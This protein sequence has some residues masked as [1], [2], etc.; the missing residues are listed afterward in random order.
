MKLPISWLNEFVNVSDISIETLKDKFVNIGFEVD[1][2]IHFGNNIENVVVGEI[3]SINKHTNSDKLFI[4]QV[5]VGQWEPLIIVTG[6]SNL[7]VGNK[8]PVALDGAILPDKKI[9]A[10]PLRGVMSYGMLCSGSELGLNDDIIEGAEVN[11]ILI[12][13]KDAPVGMDIKTFLDIDDYILDISITSNR[14]DCQSILGL[15][16][17]IA[18][19]LGRKIKLPDI[20]YE[21]DTFKKPSRKP[22]IFIDTP[23]CSRYT[24]R[25]I[26][27]VC[28]KKSPY[29]MRKRLLMCGIRPINNAVDITNY[30]LLEIGQPLHAFDFALVEGNIHVRN[31]ENGE[32]ITALNG[33]KYPLDNSVMVIADDKKAL[34]IA[35]VM[36]GEYSGI[37]E[38]TSEIY[39][40]S[41]RFNKQSIRNTSRKL[42]LSSESS[43]RYERGVDFDSIDLGR[44]RALNLFYNLKVGKILDYNKNVDKVKPEKKTITTSPSEISKLLG[45]KIER[46]DIVKILNLLNFTVKSEKGNLIIDVPGYREDIDNYTDIAEEVIRFYGYDK[47]SSTLLAASHISEGK[48]SKESTVTYDIKERLCALGCFEI[49]NFSFISDK[50]CDMLN[51]PKDSELR[52]VVKI[53]NPLSEEQSVMRTQLVSSMLNTIALNQ[54]RK[55]NS[56]RLFE[57]SKTFFD[58]G[59]D[60]PEERE[61]LCIGLYGP[62]EDFFTAKGIVESVMSSLELSFGLVRSN[63]SYLHPGLSADIVC[64]EKTIGRLGK[65]HPKVAKNFKLKNNVFVIE[66][67]LTDLELNSLTPV[68]YKELPKYHSV[69]RDLAFIVSDDITVGEMLEAIKD[70]CGTLTSEVS[71][72]DI[73]RGEG[74]PTGKYS[75][76]FSIKLQP[77]DKTLTDE[78][79]TKITDNIIKTISEKFNAILRE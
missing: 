31:A 78:E 50:T 59:N 8:V 48:R 6:A 58:I 60:L 71:L 76:A 72:F 4:C 36:G 53:R 65:I 2:V 69:D 37:N 73:Y 11:G 7:S 30:V 19:A 46:K 41:A 79:I 29:W 67:N 10:C 1:E 44:D 16:R 43:L 77:Y 40:E 35:G 57:Q 63:I 45:I 17:E 24:G 9:T 12:L 34:A 28:L 23:D 66:I 20:L 26:S 52:N 22:E 56:A 33:E 61:E 15:S 14:P 70:C 3:L 21:V 55:N 49:L 42:G 25:I 74:I 39:L 62:E 38:N 54:S 13:P 51:L 27:E 64:N 18:V 32:T 5:E 75:A 47:L 68:K